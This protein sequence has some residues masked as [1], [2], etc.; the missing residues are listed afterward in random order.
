MAS[1]SR[2]RYLRNS[3]QA[4]G[5]LA[6]ALVP[7]LGILRI[8]FSRASLL[9]LRQEVGLRDFAAMTGL[10]I[11]LAAAPL[12]TYST[13]GT[14]WCGWACPQNTLSEWADRL[15]HRMLG[16]RA[17]VHVD[18]AG[19][20]VAP[21]KNHFVNWFLLLASL[22]GVS[23]LLGLIPLFWFMPPGELV[24]LL[25]LQAEPQFARFMALLYLVFV[26]AVIV[27]IAVFRH[28]WCDYLCPY[29]FGMLLFRSDEGLHVHYDA[30]RSA[31]C[32]KCNLCMAVCVTRIE[33]TKIGRF[34]RCIDCA[35][36]ID[37]CDAL[38]ARR[39]KGAGLLA[40][41]V[42]P[43]HRNE[44]FARFLRMASGRL[45][46]PGALT[47]VGIAFIAWGVLHKG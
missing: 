44:S 31:D 39:G 5:L 34:D 1:E 8:D 37:A 14:V 13:I 20:Q 25:T 24:S 30:T 21:S 23:L 47:A 40:F 2:Y 4:L 18:G 9:L 10:A 46:I 12:L 7:A 35:E 26:V 22:L 17:N 19:L 32:A 28:F 38:H 45:G 16:R 41:R 43:D 36:C 6:L 33:P 15:T 11:V 42:G 3:T 29:R 27:D